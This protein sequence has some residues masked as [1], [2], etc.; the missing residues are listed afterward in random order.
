MPHWNQKVAKARGNDWNNKLMAGRLEARI[1][2]TLL[3][4]CR[5]K[6]GLT[7]TKLAD[8]LGLTYATYGAYESGNRPIKEKVADKISEIL[9]H[10]KLFQPIK[11]TKKVLARRANA[12]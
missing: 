6:K 3:R 4:I 5:V 2:P 7:Q 9:G 1:N 10:A 12:K 11:N 8:E